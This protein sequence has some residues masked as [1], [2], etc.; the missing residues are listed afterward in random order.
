MTDAPREIRLAD[1]A[2]YPFTF[3]EVREN[4]TRNETRRGVTTEDL[5]RSI[6]NELIIFRMT[7]TTDA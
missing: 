1:Y 2:Q 6:T 3:D 7:T 4:E 5:M